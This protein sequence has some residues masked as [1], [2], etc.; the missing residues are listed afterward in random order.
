MQ[1]GAAYLPLLHHRDCL[2]RRCRVKRGRVAA[3]AAADDDD[4]VV[5]HARP[6][7]SRQS[8]FCHLPQVL[9]PAAGSSHP[10]VAGWSGQVCSSQRSAPPADPGARSTA[11]EPPRRS[12][13]RKPIRRAASCSTTARDVFCTEST[14]VSMS[15]GT[16]VRMSM[17]STDMPSLSSSSATSTPCETHAEYVIN[18]TSA[19][20]P[21]HLRLAERDGVQ[22]HGPSLRSRR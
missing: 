2:P 5:G 10:P 4:V 17:T 9:P 12:R 18:V 3:G 8:R 21:N 16:S 22:T 19:P 14:I 11:P 13:R 1:A 20:F 6:H 7:T 15:S